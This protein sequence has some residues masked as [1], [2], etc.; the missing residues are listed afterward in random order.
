LLP[1]PFFLWSLLVLSAV[2]RF[3]L[4]NRSSTSTLTHVT[5]NWIHVCWY[6]IQLPSTY[7][8][9]TLSLLW[10]SYLSTIS[11]LN[12]YYPILSGKKYGFPWHRHPQ[13]VHWQLIAQARQVGQLA[14][15]KTV[16]YRYSWSWIPLWPYLWFTYNRI[17]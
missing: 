14:P 15:D 12:L 2:I 8:G 4:S 5:C 9:F 16:S 10:L 7:L 3:H 6:M 13:S 17:Y 1:P 11:S